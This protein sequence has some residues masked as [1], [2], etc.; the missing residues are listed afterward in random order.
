MILMMG[1]LAG[2]GNEKPTEDAP[3]VTPTETDEDYVAGPQIELYAYDA[4][5]DQQYVTIYELAAGEAI[6][7]EN[8]VK[9]YQ[10]QIMEGIYGK[11][12]QVNDISLTNISADSQRLHIDF[13][14]TDVEGLGLGSGSEGSYFGN[15]AESIAKNLP[16]ITEIYYTMDGG[17]FIT[18]HLWFSKNDPFW[19]AHEEPI[20]E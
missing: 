14:A 16:E 12:V 2:C 8:I 6:T 18:G 15:L 19:Y 20:E 7:P 4:V 3:P 1:L 9:A 5:E 11:V 17:D 10:T 13:S